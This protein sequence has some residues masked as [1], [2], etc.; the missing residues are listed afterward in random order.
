M[1]RARGALRA[2]D[3]TASVARRQA[4]LGW[5]RRA[6]ASAA[7]AALHR[8]RALSGQPSSSTRSAVRE[9]AQQRAGAEALCLQ[10]ALA[11]A[12]MRGGASWRLC[13]AFGASVRQSRWRARSKVVVA[14]LGG[15]C[16]WRAKSVAWGVGVALYCV[17]GDASG[18][19]VERRGFARIFSLLWLAFPRPLKCAHCSLEHAG[20]A[21][22]V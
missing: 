19:R 10:Y 11:S 16:V 4:R 15:G 9:A 14:L 22:D 17:R 6:G 8:A 3:S 7:S 12:A 2:R 1:Q 18:A 13:K 20:T 21:V 5:P